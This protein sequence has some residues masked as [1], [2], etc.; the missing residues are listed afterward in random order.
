LL[1]LFFFAKKMS[2]SY[3]KLVS[4]Y[5]ILVTYRAPIL[6][7]SFFLFFIFLVTL[8]SYQSSSSLSV[9][10]N[11][12]WSSCKTFG[13]STS[14]TTGPPS[15]AP[16]IG[17]KVLVTGSAGFIGSHVARYCVEELKMIVIGVDDMSGGFEFNLFQNERYTFVRGDL[18]NDAFVKKLWAEHGPFKHVYHLAAYAAEGLSHF[19]RGFNYGNNLVASM[20]VLNAAIN[21][22]TKTFVFTS[23]IAAYGAGQTPM[24]ENTV[25]QPEDPYGVAKYAVELDLKAAHE[26]FGIDFVIFRPH[27]VYGTGQNVADRYRNVI[28]IFMRQL[29]AGEPMTIFGDGLQTRA[30]SFID[31]VAPY[32]AKSP[33]IA[34]ARNQV[35]NVGADHPYT[36]N[37]LALKVKAA[38]GFPNAQVLNLPARNEVQ[39]AFSSHD[40]LRCVFRPSNPPVPLEVGLAKMAAW[41]IELSKTGSFIPVTF[42]NV[43]VTRNLPPSW[44]AASDAAAA[45]KKNGQSGNGGVFVPHT[46]SG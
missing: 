16:S 23:S 5:P 21:G 45:A 24:T 37:E 7:G 14:S 25:P 3:T 4:R 39:H 8:L 15:L 43:E 40:K 32:I 41:V 34:G 6:L 44:A 30:F 26:M 31:D 17:D 20:H 10:S 12:D 18:Q 2:F 9:S 36:L 42:G 19:I 22:G 11:E 35:F 46:K 13:L 28:G 1:T 33:L 27:N 38:M 29:L